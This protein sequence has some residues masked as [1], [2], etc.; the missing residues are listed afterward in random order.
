MRISFS[1]HTYT[2]IHICIHTHAHVQLTVN[3]TRVQPEKS[4]AERMMMTLTESTNFAGVYR[5]VYLKIVISKS[6]EREKGT[7]YLFSSKC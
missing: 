5:V 7:F 6:S 2:Y 4:S 1:A 3:K